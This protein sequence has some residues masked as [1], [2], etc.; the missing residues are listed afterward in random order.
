MK[1]ARLALLAPYLLL[2][3]PVA[4]QQ[5]PPDDARASSDSAPRAEDGACETGRI[6]H[7]FI[8]NHSIFDATD[9]EAVEQLRFAHRLANAL[10]VRTRAAVIRR[11]LLFREGDCLDPL[12]LAES[13]RL[14]R[15]LPFLSRV[16]VFVVEQP[17]GARTVDADDDEAGGNV[18]A[19]GGD[20]AS[21]SVHVVVDTQD[22]W[23]TQVDLRVR[24]D[25][26]PDFQGAAL[27]ETNLLGTG[28]LI[29]LF[30]HERGVTQD[31]GGTLHDPQL[32]GTRW[33]LTLS[34]GR[35]RAGNFAS[36]RLAYPFVGE[37]GR[38]AARQSYLRRDRFFDHVV[39]DSPPGERH[40]LVPYLE[41][42][43]DVAGV[44]R[45]GE[46]GRLTMVGAAV[47]GRRIRFPGGLDAARLTLGD[48]FDAREPAPAELAA[49]LA[50]QMHPLDNLR[51]Y[52]LLGRR[53]IRWV[54]RRGIDS[55]RGEQDIR[56]GRSASL[57][58]GRSL[59]FGDRDD[60]LF[61]TIGLYGGFERGRTLGAARLR[62]D[63]RHDFDAPGGSAAWEDVLAE[64]ELFAYWRSASP[65]GHTLVA[66]A[67]AAGGWNARLP[68]QLTLG[69]P[70]GVRGFGD[71]R[72]PG[73]RR[74]VL[75][76]EDRIHFGW[77]A[78]DVL[79]LGATVFADVG[80]VWPSGVPY[81]RDSGWRASA[82][83]GLRGAFP[84]RGRT[85]YRIDVATPIGG[86][87][88]SWRDVRLLISVGETHGLAAPFGD[89]Q[90]L[91]SRQD[92]IAGGLLD[93]PN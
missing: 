13:E 53:D 54:Q 71:E 33:D 22:E 7:I 56:L 52:L 73:G 14:L 81:G 92:G 62:L 57:A 27:R 64:A 24:W 15:R 93:F 35:T 80:R 46:P 55:F 36:Q 89:R 50:D 8:D 25:D 48:D 5:R 49:P 40:L 18:D 51:A 30:Y 78:P 77:P 41:E 85:T 26:G 67:A 29:G 84:A 3:A 45:F 86:A 28:R 12:L 17:E 1:R 72:F 44:R 4:A 60:D 70:R 10:H 88:W 79:D 65:P 66:R 38:W 76:L 6:E 23:S 83:L 87:G 68:F 39:G 2:A 91:R 21:E 37:T 42:S 61:A 16:D 63:A 82:G 31:Y 90:M 47:A 75:T 32:A 20:P 11:E 34:G 43:W 58:V 9:S 19:D 69:G 74:V 59:P